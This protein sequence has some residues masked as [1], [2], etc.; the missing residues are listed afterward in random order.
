[1]KSIEIYKVLYYNKNFSDNF[2]LQV[3]LNALIVKD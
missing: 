3:N 2:M 1:M